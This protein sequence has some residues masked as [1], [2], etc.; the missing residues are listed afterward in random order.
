M[1]C[2]VIGIDGGASKTTA[3]VMNEDQQELGRARQ[4]SG[5]LPTAGGGADERDLVGGHAGCHP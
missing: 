3:V 1:T 4:R 2:Y 5:Q